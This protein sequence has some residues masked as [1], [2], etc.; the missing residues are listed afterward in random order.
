MTVTSLGSFSFINR[1]NDVTAEAKDTA[2]DPY[3]PITTDET[4]TVIVIDAGHGG[5]DSGATGNGY[6]EKNLTLKIAKAVKTK[7]EEYSH[8]KVYLSRANDTYVGLS[9]R[10]AYA[11]SVGAD[12]FISIHLNSA[13][14]SAP[15]GCEVYYPNNHYD[16]NAFTVGKSLATNIQKNLKALGLFD[17]QIKTKSSANGSRYPDGSLADYYAVIRTSKLKHI[18]G[19]IVEGAFISSKND[20]TKYLNSDAKIQKMAAADANGIATTF[21]LSLKSD[22][23]TVYP[24]TVKLSSAKAVGSA[25]DVSVTWSA[26]S[27]ASEYIVFR[28]TGKSGTYKEITRTTETSYTD[29]TG[30]YGNTYYYTVIARNSSGR[31][32]SY[33]SNGVSVKIPNRTVTMVSAVDNG[34]SRVKVTWTKDP[35]AA[36]YRVYRSTKGGKYTKITT[37]N[38][39]AGSYT[40]E[41]VAK[42]TKYDYAVKAYYKIGKATV[43]GTCEKGKATVTTDGDTAP[44]LTGTM[45]ADGRSIVF[46]WTASVDPDVTYRLYKKVDDGS[47]VRVNDGMKE[48]TYTDTAL[49]QGTTYSYRVRFYRTSV[50]SSKKTFWSSYSNVLSFTTP[51]DSADTASSDD[52][53][54][55]SDSTVNSSKS[56]VSSADT[57][58]G[59][60]DS[61]STAVTT[62]DQIKT[63]VIKWRSAYTAVKSSSDKTNYDSDSKDYVT[64]A[65][66][67]SLT[68]HWYPIEGVTGYQ[69]LN[70]K[71]K[72]VTSVRGDDLNEVT[73][74]GLKARTSYTY[75]V[76]AFIKID[77]KNYFSP[78]S[79]AASGTTAY[80]IKGSSSTTPQQMARYYNSMIAKR[81]SSYPSDTYSQYGAATIDDFTQIVYDEANKVGIKAEVLFAQI[82]N[83]TGFLTFGG[84]VSAEQCNFG[85]IGAVG[86]G[87]NG[88]DFVSY[89][90]NY[91]SALRYADPDSAVSDAVRVGIRAQATHLAL[92][93]TTDGNIPSYSSVPVVSGQTGGTIAV[94]DPRASS[95]IIGTAPYVEWLGIKDNHYTT[96]EAG[97]RVAKSR[98][99]AAANNYGY[100]LIN[101][102]ITPLL[103]A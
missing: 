92:Y 51:G 86:G 10:T 56:T 81:K 100:T 87:T 97:D 102:Y 42:N 70:S 48:L 65:S 41:S 27:D 88:M 35:S 74:T 40:D 13:S 43:W 77:G 16:T 76:R 33:D 78:S 68:L 21:G 64:P 90:R 82:C 11:A 47:Y 32:Q 58:A 25:N 98:G 69:V 75:K 59:G 26:T 61:S 96:G 9:D 54:S 5:S 23:D 95:S 80:A 53:I 79:T 4:D 72:R 84:D 103:K 24:G 101:S 7:L 15:N 3:D 36:G 46:N 57:A 94:P 12:A 29:S 19:I 38:K 62:A 93:A 50:H 73:V 20:V 63:A 37:I 39:Q 52:T 6:K 67:T 30:S 1:T 28:K 17:R 71:G 55:A 49:E 44:T 34:L 85:G 45:A 2:G 83:E 91:Y 89:A 8:V 31:S 99:W 22:D 60:S 66:E 18:P 14:T